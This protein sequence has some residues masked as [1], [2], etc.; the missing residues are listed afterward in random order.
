M[1]P[2]RAEKPVVHPQ[3]WMGLRVV[4][5]P[6]RSRH[7]RVERSNYLRE[8]CL[9]TGVQSWT[10]RCAREKE[11]GELHAQE[12]LVLRS[13]SGDLSV[14]GIPTPQRAGFGVLGGS[15]PCWP[16]YLHWHCA[17]DAGDPLLPAATF[18]TRTEKRVSPAQVVGHPRGR[19]AF[20]GLGVCSV[21]RRPTFVWR[22]K[23]LKNF[24]PAKW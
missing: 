7:M 3:H 11:K 24:S 14:R 21:T 6:F 12:A 23:A 19:V 16:P 5:S 1:G 18:A 13:S 15:W 10:G 2:Q 9:Q 4:A 17:P 8:L 22:Q 20:P